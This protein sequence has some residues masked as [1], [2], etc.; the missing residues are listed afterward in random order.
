MS[1][2]Q[3]ILLGS[4]WVIAARWGIR[5]IGFVS[6]LILVRL[7]TPED[8]GVVAMAMLVVGIVEVF[9][10]T[11]LVL[12][13]IRHPDPQPS[14]FDTVWTLRA[15]IGAA[16]AAILFFAAP[17]GGEFFNQPLL[18]EVVRWLALRPLMV[19]LENPGIVWFRKNMEFHRDF[20]FLVLN[21]VASFV[22]TIALAAWLRDYWALVFGI[23]AGGLVSLLQSYRMHPYRPRPRLSNVRAAWSYSF[24]LLVQ[25]VLVFANDRLDEVVVGRLKTTTDLGQYAVASDLAASPLREIV[26]PLSRALFPG[27][28]LLASDQQALARSFGRVLAGVAIVAFSVSGGLAMV[29]TDFTHV[30]LGPQWTPAAPLLRL[31][32]VGAGFFALSQPIFSLLG[33]T[34]RVRAAAALSFLRLAALSAAIL[35][36][37]YLGDLAD[38]AAG[39]LAA[40]ALA[41]VISIAAFLRLTAI[42]TAVVASALIRPALATL[43][44]C[45][46]V[47]AANAAAPDWPA[48][49]LAIA[50]PVGALAFAAAL[51][52]L[53]ALQGKP[54]AAEA[55]FLALARRFLR[56]AAPKQA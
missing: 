47:A 31:L 1:V 51:F 11:G 17:L 38:V 26:S 37:A 48:L 21:K 54:D 25:H 10:E 29:A 15:L 34:G 30:V 13:L 4:V 49:R 14:D 27:F 50:V 16:L 6:T 35:P 9:G 43:V 52:G 19:G 32:A 22:V 18:T 44:M 46:C 39:R 53:W 36:A 40:V 2:N 42:P 23:L 24:W 33:A 12:Y 7:L 28:V 41:S 3:R 56:R 20:E 45:G 5:A 8:F 55:D